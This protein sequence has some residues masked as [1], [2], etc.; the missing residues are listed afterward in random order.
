MSCWKQEVVDRGDAIKIVRGDAQIERDPLFA[1]GA[2]IEIALGRRRIDIGLS[3]RLILAVTD[4][5]IEVNVLSEAVNQSRSAETQAP[6]SGL[7]AASRWRMIRESVA[8]H[9][10][11]QTGDRP[12][13]W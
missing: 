1:E 5:R 4:C 2:Q 8:W 13:P 12:R 3:Q 11:R 10:R 9:R 6:E 7:P